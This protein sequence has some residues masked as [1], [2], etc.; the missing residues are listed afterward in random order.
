MEA[1]LGENHPHIKSLFESKEGED[2]LY[3]LR[4]QLA[5]GGITFLDPNHNKMIRKKLGELGEIV[6]DF[7]K[8]IIIKPDQKFP[9]W[10]G[11]FSMSISFFTPQNTMIAN[12]DKMFPIKD[13]RIRLEWLD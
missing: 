4:G 5:H 13:W 11:K 12:T 1:V 10:S 2:S 6:K 9:K 7:V 3:D 8:K